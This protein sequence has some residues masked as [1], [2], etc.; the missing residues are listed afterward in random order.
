MSSR[1]SGS[2]FAVT[3]HLAAI[4]FFPSYKATRV[5]KFAALNNNHR[6]HQRTTLDLPSINPQQFPYWLTG[7][8]NPVRNLP[9]CPHADRSEPSC[10]EWS[11][12]NHLG[13]KA[14]H[15]A[16]MNDRLLRFQGVARPS[17][18]RKGS[19]C[20]PVQQAFD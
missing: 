12:K 15:F 2:S 8:T 13:L 14:D 19:L 10:K 16:L 4:R 7:K 1:L 20:L 18:L 3:G 11:Q 6:P 9:A 5:P 17:R